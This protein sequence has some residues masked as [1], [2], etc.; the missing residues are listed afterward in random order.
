MT[1]TNCYYVSLQLGKPEVLESNW[2]AEMNIKEGEQ[3]ELFVV[4]NQACNIKDLMLLKDKNKLADSEA[5]KLTLENKKAEDGSERCEVKMTIKDAIPPDSGKYRLVFVD[6][7]GQKPKEIELG[8]TS[9]KVE[10][11]PYGVLEAL[12]ADK[13]TYKPGEDIVLSIKLSKPLID[14]QRNVSFMLN[15]KTINIKDIT[16]VEEISESLETVYSFVIK[17]AKPGLHDGEYSLK[18]CSKVNDMKSQFYSG[19]V[20]VAFEQDK[21]MVN[22]GLPNPN[23]DLINHF[24]I[25]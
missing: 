5:V 7:A 13:V 25:D 16:L 17:A 21:E 3:L 2:K 23:H 19:V 4:I 11:S 22:P 14:K 8:A 24:V 10:E 15:G 9:L 20:T 12:K 6:S 18:L 1:I